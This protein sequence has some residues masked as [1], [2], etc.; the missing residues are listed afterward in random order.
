MSNAH[1]GLIVNNFMF[2]G[3]RDLQ[4]CQY[5]SRRRRH[6]NNNNNSNNHHHHH[7]HHVAIMELGHFSIRSD[8]THPE[9]FSL[10]FSGSFRLVV[11]V[12]YYPR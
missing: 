1:I 10:I 9:V 5:R 6:N 11:C 4:I 3:A 7:H 12:F 2:H 8:N